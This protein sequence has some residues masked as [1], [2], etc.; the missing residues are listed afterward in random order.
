M[1]KS[2]ELG[3]QNIRVLRTWRGWS[4]RE[5]A[6]ATGLT[7]WRIFKLEKGLCHPRAEEIE[8]IFEALKSEKSD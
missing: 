3:V 1:E 5:L 6:V 2:T 7:P 4:Q 8:K